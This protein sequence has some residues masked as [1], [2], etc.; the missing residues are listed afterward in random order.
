[1]AATDGTVTA[2]GPDGRF[3]WSYDVGA[4]VQGALAVA[5]DVTYVG[6]AE[7]RIV[8]LKSNGQK[9]WSYRVRTPV[10]SDL[11]V[12]KDG[13]VR[14]AGADGVVYAVTARGGAAWSRA[15]RD[16]VSAGPCLGS[17][18]SVLVGTTSG[19]IVWIDAFGR[20]R[21]VRV[22]AGILQQ[23]W[24]GE[25]CVYAVSGSDLLA[26]DE[27]GTVRWRVPRVRAFAV[28]AGRVV[29]AESGGRLSWWTA[30]GRLEQ[31][32]ETAERPSDVPVVAADGTVYVPTETGTVLV[33]ED[34]RVAERVE[35]GRA[36]VLRPRLDARQGQ[37]V[38]VAGDG[39]VV[40]VATGDR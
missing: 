23:E 40:G 10:L 6:T 22:R 4:S 39:V 3:R 16:R 28:A 14:F 1:M 21:D 13:V 30:A 18:D 15:L 25:R 8:A 24:G 29:A 33:V 31:V 7:G 2:L 36:A 26:L 32:V 27:D 12:G 37:L 11:V 5:G 9:L 34:G 20:K 38:A 19:R 17:N 35:V